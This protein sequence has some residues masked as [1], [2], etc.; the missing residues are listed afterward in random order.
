PAA[1]HPPRHET[2][3]KSQTSREIPP[4][5]TNLPHPAQRARRPRLAV[6]EEA[7]AIGLGQPRQDRGVPRKRRLKLRPVSQGTRASAR[8][9]SRVRER[10]AREFPTSTL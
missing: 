3:T 4:S 9:P 8:K 7:E 1:A 6:A 2:P 5:T 10:V